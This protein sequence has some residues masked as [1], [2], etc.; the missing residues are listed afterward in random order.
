MRFR[1][2]G[3]IFLVLGQFSAFADT[4]DDA[5]ALENAGDVNG[6][7]IIYGVWLENSPGG[8]GYADVLHHAAFLSVNPLDTL[9]LI[10]SY[11]DKVHVRDSYRLYANMAAVESS[12]GLLSESSGHYRL[13]ASTPG[14]E[15]EQWKLEE[16]MLRFKMGEY[17]EVQTQAVTLYKTATVP[18]IREESLALSAICLS[19]EGRASEA[20]HLLD[21][22]ID[23]NPVLQSPLPL[24]VM[25]E[26]AST[27]GSPDMAGKAE[28]L[29][30]D[31]FP[32]S[33]VQYLVGARVLEWISPAAY[34]EGFVSIPGK[35][36]QVG[37]FGSRERSAS[38][39][40]RL[41]YDG[42]TAWI[43]QHGDIWKVFVNDSDGTVLSRLTSAGYGSLF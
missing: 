33:A 11:M 3:I 26:I 28:K 31:R 43:E 42:F 16:L 17:P 35:S 23:S 9:K 13:A 14:P 36:V 40:T 4:L 6:A 39:R 32:G 10:S 15:G 19:R 29:L 12:I 25:R 7:L 21:E 2:F 41:E 22:Y 5:R 30:A 1:F 18:G 38:L 20:L 37:A 8:S 24:Y 34:V 27:A